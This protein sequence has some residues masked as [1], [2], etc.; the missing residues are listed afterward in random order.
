MMAN[1][2]CCLCDK[3][4]SNEYFPKIKVTEINC[5]NCG[6]YK[7]SERVKRIINSKY[8]GK[9]HLFSGYFR[10]LKEIGRKPEKV[11]EDNIDTILS[12][13]IIPETALEKLDKLLLYFDRNTEFIYQKVSIKKDD[14]A[15][16]YS[17]NKEE[18]KNMLEALENQ[19]YIS[20]EGEW[21]W[22][23]GE[24]VKYKLTLDGISEINKIKEKQIENT[25]QAFVAMWFGDQMMEV[26][27]KYSRT[28]S[29][30]KT[31]L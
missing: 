1:D 30:K 31:T 5:K 26:Y 22:K 25:K 6:R 21:G 13:T 10:E 15:I 20:K 18:L 19:E 16:S 8:S 23:N 12:N 17:K 9:S 28:N 4:S 27:D 29:A 24:K 7:I 3:E 14:T 11:T 2:K